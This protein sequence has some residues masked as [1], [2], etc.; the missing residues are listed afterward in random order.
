M[1]D[2]ATQPPQQQPPPLNNGAANSAREEQIDLP[3]APQGASV[4]VK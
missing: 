4:Q 1:T 2:T 3:C